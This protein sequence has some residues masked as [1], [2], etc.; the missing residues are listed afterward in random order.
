MFGGRRRRGNI[1][2]ELIIIIL[3]I[4]QHQVHRLLLLS[5]R[6]IPRLRMKQE[7]LVT[8]G[9]M[10][11]YKTHTLRRHKYLFIAEELRRMC[12]L[13]CQSVSAAQLTAQKKTS[14]PFNHH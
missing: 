10:L 1:F 11:F 12:R 5:Q 9:Q 4:Q 7:T 3:F 8:S 13:G 2:D 6:S 14:L